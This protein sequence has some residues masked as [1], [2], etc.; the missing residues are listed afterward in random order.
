MEVGFAGAVVGAAVP[1]GAG[2]VVLDAALPAP[3]VPA[4]P[5]DEEGAPPVGAAL[6]TGAGPAGVG[7]VVIGV[8]AS[9]RGFDRADATRVFNSFSAGSFLLRSLYTA[10]STSR[11]AF[12]SAG[13]VLAA[14]ARA[15]ASI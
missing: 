11:N 7:N 5:A 8:G 12:L 14:A 2:L 4:L 6:P 3:L 9:G 13:V 1:V 10:A 15:N